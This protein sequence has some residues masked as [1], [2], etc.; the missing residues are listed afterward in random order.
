VPKMVHRLNAASATRRA[1]TKRRSAAA[2]RDDS[3]G[4]GRSIDVDEDLFATRELE[5]LSLTQVLPE[6]E[7]TAGIVVLSTG[8]VRRPELDRLDDVVATVRWPVLGVIDH[9]EV[10]SP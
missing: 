10:P 5:V 9:P 4:T 2:A 8:T 1:S 7:L 6:H 3:R